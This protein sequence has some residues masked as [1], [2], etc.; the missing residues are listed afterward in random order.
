MTFNFFLR[1]ITAIVIAPIVIFI[2]YLGGIFFYL[3]LLLV[4]FLC[5][6]EVLKVK[7]YKVNIIMLLLLLLFIHSSY[8]IRSSNNGILH[9]Y[10]VVIISWLSDTGGYFFGKFFRGPKIKSISPN[11]TYTGFVGSLIFSQLSIVYIFFFDLFSELDF[12]YKI[13]IVFTS[14]IAVI[15]GDLLFSYF[16]R[17]GNI[18][19]YS[20]ILPGHGGL[21]D[22]IDGLIVLMILYNLFG[23]IL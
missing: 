14:S 23:N 6:Y 11:K 20:N 1:L 3:L 17:V 22:R 15:C 19:D 5:L 2:I 18:K 10:F 9:I 13:L 7:N 4:F 12:F 21:L 8:L 16:K